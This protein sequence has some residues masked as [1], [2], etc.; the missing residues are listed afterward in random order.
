MADTYIANHEAVHSE[1]PKGVNMADQSPIT[2]RSDES[3]NHHF[4]N[5]QIM[6]NKNQ[7]DVVGKI[8]TEILETEEDH[9][10]DVMHDRYD[11]AYGRYSQNQ[12][13]RP[14]KAGI[15]KSMHSLISGKCFKIN[16]FAHLKQPI[17]AYSIKGRVPLTWMDQL[18]PDASNFAT[19]TQQMKKVFRGSVAARISVS[20]RHPTPHPSHISKNPVMST[21]PKE[22][23]D[24]L[25][26]FLLP[27]L[28]PKTTPFTPASLTIA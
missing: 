12:R 23:T 17:Q 14:S 24:S 25:H 21:K 5:E 18:E 10:R 15:S 27:Q 9:Y 7:N 28:S 20:Y 16:A 26:P 19:V 1:T 4:E 6:L 13:I 11:E 8:E 3:S 22:R 2:P